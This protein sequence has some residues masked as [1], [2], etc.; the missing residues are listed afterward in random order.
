MRK[1]LTTLMIACTGLAAMPPVLAQGK[2]YDPPQRLRAGAMDSC[3]KDEAMNGAY[4]VKQC[5]EGFRMEMG[6]R[7][8]SCI[9]TTPG[10]QVPPP[11]RPDFTP[12]K[13][14][15]VDPKAPKGA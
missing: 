15:P 11:P 13:P 3:M 5:A 10:A 1:L 6:K 4:C 12:G 2:R 14:P 8:A 9:A 7:D